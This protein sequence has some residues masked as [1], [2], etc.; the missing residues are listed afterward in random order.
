MTTTTGTIRALIISRV[1]VEYSADNFP[2]TT[3]EEVEASLR[4]F[5]GEFTSELQDYIPWGEVE[6][7]LFIESSLTET[8]H[9]NGDAVQE[10]DDP[11]D[12]EEPAI[13]DTESEESDIPG[14]TERMNTDAFG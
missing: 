11:E 5:A 8:D 7:E 12:D 1:T 2:G 6:S 10:A 3:P 13:L 4:E 9:E 14:F